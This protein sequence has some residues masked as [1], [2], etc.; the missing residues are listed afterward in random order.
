[1]K[2]N[3]GTIDR[4]AR[5]VVTLGI[6]GMY[7]GNVISGTAAIVLGSVAV[8]FALTSAAGFCPLYWPFKVST[9]KVA[10]DQVVHASLG[11]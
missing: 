2:R 3:M 8:I 1:M 4:I 6:T 11:D 5:I 10:P 7:F 9:K